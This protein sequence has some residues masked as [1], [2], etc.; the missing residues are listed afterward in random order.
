MSVPANY[1]TVRL[2]VNPQHLHDSAGQLEANVAEINDALGDVITSLGDLKLSWTGP[3]SDSASD[4]NQR[5]G[6]AMT[7]LF[8]TQDDPSQGVLNV[9]TDGLLG[10]AQNYG[11]N[12]YQIKQMYQKFNDLMNGSSSGAA[13]NVVDAPYG[14]PFPNY[15]TTS[16]NETG[17]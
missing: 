14:T 15:H 11:S 4:F 17:F 16:V 8:G 1:D 9:M 6:A 3:A 5:W 2:N 13:A 12:E 7:T 10:A